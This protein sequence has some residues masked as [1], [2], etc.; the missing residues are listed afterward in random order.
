MKAGMFPEDDIRVAGY[1]YNGDGDTRK[2][3]L[4]IDPSINILSAAR[5]T[6]S[7]E[8]CVIIRYILSL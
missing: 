1:Y 3:I 4:A 7:G 6:L 8:R 5:W 2:P